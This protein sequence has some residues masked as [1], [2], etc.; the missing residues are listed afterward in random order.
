LKK[1]FAIG[2]PRF[3]VEASVAVIVILYNVTFLHYLG[4]NGVTAYAMVNYIH[5][6][7]LTIFLGVGMAL[8][9][10]VSYHHGARLLERLTALLKIGLA[11]AFILG[12][13]TA[14]IALLFPS[15][16]MALFGDS[17]FDI[18]SM[19][20]Q[21]FVHFA[22]GYVFLGINMVFA[23][24]FQSIEKIRIATTIMLLRSII[25]FIP[26]LIILPKILGSQAIWWTFPVAEGITALLIYLFIRKNP[27]TLS[28]PDHA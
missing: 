18:R 22:I 5:T 1:I 9:P 6:V 13:T 11:T 24:F 19:A 20:A 8:Q 7:L 14:L 15:Q 2:L 16:L 3:I 4:A 21:G 23:E 10:L 12:L 25:L 28:S 27:R 26:T 17:S